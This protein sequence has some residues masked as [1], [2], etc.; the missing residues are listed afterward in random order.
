MNPERRR[1]GITKAKRVAKV[2]KQTSYGD[3]DEEAFMQGHI[4]NRKKCSCNMCCN[5]TLLSLL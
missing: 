5:G 4:K 2:W 3:F 1:K